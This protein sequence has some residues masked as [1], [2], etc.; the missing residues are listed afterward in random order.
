MTQE[1]QGLLLLALLTGHVLGDF[2]LQGQAWVKDRNS[3]HERSPFLY[4]HALLHAIITL[5][6]CLL[7][8]ISW[9]VAL[10]VTC[11]VLFSHFGFDLAKSFLPPKQSWFVLDQLLHV[12]VLVLLWI[13]ITNTPLQVTLISQFLTQKNLVILLAYLLALTPVSIITAQALKQWDLDLGNTDKSLASAGKAIGMLE[14]FLIVTFVLLDQFAG[15][16]FLMAAKSIF[17]FGDL[18]ESRDHKMTEY[19]MMG[20][21]LSF[22]LALL[23]G[24]AAAEA[25]KH[26]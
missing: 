3:K 13:A 14:R 18:R 6:I 11:A 4:I 23:I 7:F 2:Y 10:A 21:L 5:V 20:T 1:Q 12:C 8:P 9:P 24:L 16:G 17:R 15:I 19:V 22:I 26:L 25:A